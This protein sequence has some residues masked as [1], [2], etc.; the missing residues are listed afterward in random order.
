MRKFTKLCFLICALSGCDTT[1]NFKEPIEYAIVRI[2]NTQSDKLLSVNSKNWMVELLKECSWRQTEE[3]LV[4][5]YRFEIKR[6]RDHVIGQL[7]A[8]TVFITSEENNIF[9][10]QITGNEAQEF[11]A[12]FN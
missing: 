1:L 12:L 5:S 4:S 10:C 8:N 6:K 11:I 7:V 9:E 2:P 3:D